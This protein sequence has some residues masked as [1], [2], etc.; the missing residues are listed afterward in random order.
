VQRRVLTGKKEGGARADSPHRIRLASATS[1]T[2]TM[3]S[4]SRRS[5]RRV[6]GAHGD[7][8]ERQDA[9]VH[10]HAREP[11]GRRFSSVR[12]IRSEQREARQA[13]PSPWSPRSRRWRASRHT[14]SAMP[15][16][17]AH[18]AAI[19]TAERSGELVA[20]VVEAEQNVAPHEQHH[21]Q[22]EAVSFRRRGAAEPRGLL[23]AA[24]S[25]GAS[26]PVLA[27]WLFLWR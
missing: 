19:A 5:R 26:C 14:L 7:R 17:S 18:Q 27:D 20:A 1:T 9:H 25:W 23:R 22:G 24:R 11:R 8:D 6:T 13:P 10:Q 3:P 21:R 12:P 16:A 4:A 2:P 15:I